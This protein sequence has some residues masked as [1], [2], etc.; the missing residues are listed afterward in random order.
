VLLMVKRLRQALKG[1]KFRPE[2]VDWTGG[3]KA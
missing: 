2:E 3:K 1:P